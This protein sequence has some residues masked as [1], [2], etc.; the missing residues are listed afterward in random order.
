[1]SKLI[2]AWGTEKV[3]TR[4]HLAIDSICRL[5]TSF[6]KAMECEKDISEQMSKGI[7]NERLWSEQNRCRAMH[8]KEIDAQI[9]SCIERAKKL[10]KRRVIEDLEE[11][12][13]A[14]RSALVKAQRAP[15]N[16]NE[17]TSRRKDIPDGMG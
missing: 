6:S 9:Q 12:I 15:R 3:P 8:L 10:G 7:A 11:V 2:V 4:E 16:P 5:H 17:F 14:A 1:M 13:P